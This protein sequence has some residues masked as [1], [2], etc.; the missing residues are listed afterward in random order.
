MFINDDYALYL[1]KELPK[2]D[3]TTDIKHI[4][5]YEVLVDLYYCTLELKEYIDKRNKNIKIVK[6]N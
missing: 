4:I 5:N 1:L 2:I 3:T 6:R